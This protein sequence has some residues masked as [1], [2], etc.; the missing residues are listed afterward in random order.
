MSMKLS[1]YVVS[2]VVTYLGDLQPT[3]IGLI[4]YLQSTMDIPVV[5]FLWKWITIGRS[6]DEHIPGALPIWYYSDIV[7][8]HIYM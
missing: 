8:S 3:Y 4:I 5:F 2:W 7:I 6:I 1:N